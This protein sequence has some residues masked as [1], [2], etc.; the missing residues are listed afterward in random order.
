MA[1][2]SEEHATPP[3]AGG[4][5]AITSYFN[6]L[7]YRRRRENYK[8]FRERLGVPLVAVELA[9]D[10]DFDLGEGDADILIQLRDG[11]ILFQKERLLNIAL[12]AVP[13]ACTR[14]AWIDCDVVFGNRGWAEQAVRLL[15]G[16]VPMVHLFSHVHY[17]PP[18]LPAVDIGVAASRLRRTSIAFAEISGA[19]MLAGFEEANHQPYGDH[20]PGLAWAG[21]RDLFAAH[22][23]Y[24]A[25][26]IGGGDRALVS[27]R[28]GYFDYVARRHRMN[29]RE[30]AYYLD[31]A[32]PFHD[33]VGKAIACVEGDL[34]HLWH[35]ALENR[36]FRERHRGLS[37][38]DYD[39]HVDLTVGSGG[40]W[41]WNSDKPAMHAYVRDHFVRRREDE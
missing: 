13:P 8:V 31:W 34:F 16:G 14:F 24:D 37:A 36:R 6:P 29:D 30:R 22:G 18:D 20:A 11:D 19:D 10:R 38:F 1:D 15:D 33:A 12:A 28:F 17:M 9:R 5:W 27:A 35:G 23:F 32:E 39:P 40:A 25:C 3:D 21:R 2:G 4:L 7:G 41:R 26:I